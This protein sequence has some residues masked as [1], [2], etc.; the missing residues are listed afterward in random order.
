MSDGPET[1][2]IDSGAGQDHMTCH[3]ELFTSYQAHIAPRLA[4]GI[5]NS[6]V[7]VTGSGTVHLKLANGQTLK[8]TDVSYAP[9][10]TCNLLAIAPLLDEGAT[11]MTFT[12]KTCHVT[13]VSSVEIVGI[14]E[15]SHWYL[16]LAHNFGHKTMLSDRAFKLTG[17]KGATVILRG[18]DLGVDDKYEN[19]TPVWNFFRA[20]ATRHLHFRS[21]DCFMTEDG[22]SVHDKYSLVHAIKDMMRKDRGLAHWTMKR[23]WMS[24]MSDS[25]RIATRKELVE[26]MK[27]QY[28]GKLG[29]RLAPW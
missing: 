18:E 13:T 29:T 14:R 19:A 28:R 22:R 3:R 26:R 15:G 1:W 20:F 21:R 12:T 10:G 9:R 2:I 4:F 8:L 11:D 27:E 7:Q 24:E 17:L 5:S 23:T 6:P 16:D 25:E